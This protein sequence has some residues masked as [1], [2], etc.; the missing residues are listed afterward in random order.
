MSI[1]PND[2][3]LTAYA[4]GELEGE[5]LQSFEA[6]LADDGAAASEL[7]AIRAAAKELSSELSDSELSLTAEQRARIE[8]AAE[9]PAGEAEAPKAKV[10]LLRR[11]SLWAISAVAAVLPLALWATTMTT[12]REAA[13][14][15]ALA[16]K[17]KM[18]RE[19]GRSAGSKGDGSSA[20]D[21][22]RGLT[23]GRRYGYRAGPTT[24]QTIQHGKLRFRGGQSVHLR[25]DESAVDVLDRRRHGVL[26][27]VRR[28]LRRADSCRR[29]TPCASRSW[30]TTS[31]T[32]IRS[33]KA[34]TRSPCPREVAACPWAPTH[35]LVS[36]RPARDARST[37]AHGPPRNL[38]FLLDVSGSMETPD[39]L[40][41]LKQRLEAA[42]R[43]AARERPRR[44]RGLRRRVGAGA[45]ST[46]PGDQQRR[47][48]ATR[49]TG[50]QAGGSTNG[51]AGIELAYDVARRALH[52]GRHQPRHPRHRRRLQRRRHEPG[53]PGAA[54]RGE[55]QGGRVP[56][57]CSASAWATSRTR[58]W[59]SSPTR[60]TATTPTSTRIDEARKVLV[61]QTGRHPRDDREGRE[62]PG[63]VQPGAWSAATA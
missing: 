63:R 53:R 43:P 57:A 49:S 56:D 21:G 9:K 51:G 3:R 40:P 34:A 35:R 52:P 33:P 30:S 7:E 61:E 20:S 48:P 62:D 2:P 36:H 58:R 24:R 16:S 50:S 8:R 19:I 23:A 26:R 15:S 37:S 10:S 39:K 17:Y 45:A 13:P 46:T 18:P 5:D 27:N 44:H 4:L 11:K 42:R 31:A 29:R 60:A 38:V 54:D 55:A 47:D 25:E 12:G 41:L 14:V 28:F 22:V 6:L 32:T 59:R 1:E